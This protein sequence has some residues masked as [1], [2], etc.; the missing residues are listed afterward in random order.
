MIPLQEI[1]D[2]ISNAVLPIL[3]ESSL[4]LVDVEF[5]PS[6][7]RWLLRI[8]IDKEG[9]VSIGDCEWVSRELD[10]LLDAE[11]IIDHPYMLEVSSPGLT[12]PLKRRQDFERNRGKRCKII[13]REIIDG[14]NEF[15][16]EIGETSE[17]SVA[18]NA[19]GILHQIPL[20]TIKK[21]NLEFEL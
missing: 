10:R 12:R 13:T 19:E 4:D 1:V 11:D 17:D 2:K 16:G 14:K 8:F 9:G 21:A 20:A 6:G 3:R 15:K 5:L 7:R 18:V